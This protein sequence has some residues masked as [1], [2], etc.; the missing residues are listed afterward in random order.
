MMHHKIILNANPLCFFILLLFA[1]FLSIFCNTK[2]CLQ[3][4][5]FSVLSMFQFVPALET[6][7]TCFDNWQFKVIFSNPLICCAEVGLCAFC[8]CY[9]QDSSGQLLYSLPLPW[10]KKKTGSGMRN[11]D[12]HGKLTLTLSQK[13]TVVLN[14]YLAIQIL[15]LVFPRGYQ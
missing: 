1:F 11:C 14:F 13:L 10:K 12:N 3:P 15:F 9:I 2:V 6:C 8:V 7:C 4:Q 5:G